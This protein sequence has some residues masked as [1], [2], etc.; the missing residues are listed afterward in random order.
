MSAVTSEENRKPRLSR[1]MRDYAKSVDVTKAHGGASALSAADPRARLYSVSVN[2]QLLRKKN[3][4]GRAFKTYEAAEEAGR[5]E[6][7]RQRVQP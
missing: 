5:R 1:D 7:V 3:G 6:W 4:V 2:G